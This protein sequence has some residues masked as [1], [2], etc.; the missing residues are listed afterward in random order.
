MADGSEKPIRDVRVGDRVLATDP[1]TG[2]TSARPVTALIREHERRTMVALGLSD[3]S[4]I[5][6]TDLHPFWDASTATFTDAIDL[7][8]G[9]QLLTDN[10]RYLTV[11]SAHSYERELKTYNLRI[12]G[13]HAE[14]D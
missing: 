14:S 7:H 1:V 9:D 6:A 3:G 13:L 11:K 10:G 2:E 5:T 12:A 8:L 4:T